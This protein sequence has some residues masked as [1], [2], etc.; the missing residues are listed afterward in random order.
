MPGKGTKLT[1]AEEEA[2]QAEAQ[3]IAEMGSAWQPDEKALRELVEA[4]KKAGAMEYREAQSR[5]IAAARERGVRLGRPKK[6][7][8]ASF[9]DIAEA[10]GEGR[11]TRVE[12]AAKL[13]ISCETLRHWLADK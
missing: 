10:V 8:P 5:G 9:P 2:L 6:E 11:M 7:K 1:K 13:G 3:R 4:V 12:A